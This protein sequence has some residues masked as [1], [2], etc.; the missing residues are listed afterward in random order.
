MDLHTRIQQAVIHAVSNLLEA[1]VPMGF[2]ASENQ[3][4]SID[5][6]G[7]YLLGM[8]QVQGKLTGSITVSAPS[9]L[10]ISMTEAMLEEEVKDL[11]DDVYETIAEVTNIIAGGIKTFLSQQEEIFSLGL[12]QVLEL[13]GGRKLPDDKQRMVV[14]I[15]TEKGSFF[16]MSTLFE[17]VVDEQPQ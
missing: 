1:M 9:H 4:S 5:F 10:A 15:K 7:D 12:P 14:P 3:A 11:N 2:E 16:V 6:V 8:I 13:K 17:S